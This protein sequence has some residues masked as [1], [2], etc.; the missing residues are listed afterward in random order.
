ML[1]ITHSTGVL[2]ANSPTAIAHNDV[3]PN[4]NHHLAAAFA[5]LQDPCVSFMSS[6]PQEV[7]TFLAC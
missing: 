7:G 4:E 5:M 3:S 6:C 1:K 2:Q